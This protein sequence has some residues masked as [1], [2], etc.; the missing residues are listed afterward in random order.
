MEIPMNSNIYSVLSSRFMESPAAI[1]IE[2]PNGT[3]YTYAELDAEVARYANLLSSYGL[4]KGDR[5]ALQTDKSLAVVFI[6]LATVRAGFVFMP[7]NPDSKAEDAEYYIRD[8]KPK[9]FIC[10]PS[11]VA[12]AR[13]LIASSDLQI[14]HDLDENGIGSITKDSSEFPVTFHTAFNAENDLA[15]LMYTSGTTGRPKGSMLT[16]RNLV[17]NTEVLSKLWG[18]TGKDVLVH[19]L[20]TFHTHGLFVAIHL[21]LYGSGTIIFEDAFNPERLKKLL[22]VATVFMGVPPYYVSLLDQ[23][24]LDRDICSHMRLFICGSAPLLPGV[25]NSFHTRTGHTILERYGMTEGGMLT[26][27]P[28]HGERKAGTVGFALPGSEVRIVDDGGAPLPVGVIGHVQYKGGNLFRGYWNLPEKTIS[29]FT[30]DGFFKTGDMGRMDAEGY[31]SIL[32]RFKDVI[33]IDG[34]SIYPRE[35]EALI[36][37]VPGVVESA[38]V[39]VQ[40]P[41]CPPT[42]A[43]VIVPQQHG[44][45]QSI[46]RTVQEHLAAKLPPYKL[47]HTLQWVSQLPRNSMGKVQKNVLRDRLSMQATP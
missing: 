12:F 4:Q 11:L 19:M 37:S 1:A 18:F 23:N 29:E 31:L 41:G 34:Q 35:I 33:T 17:S 7:I 24:W 9:I 43:A 3:R 28:L 45:A 27:N 25:F 32:G 40:Q 47:P 39:G 22:P 38:V 21:P 8:A 2:L 44:D 46:Q 6:Y 42:V 36:D 5:V 20:P 10:K 13:S 16:H 14:V 30:S 15:A 26:S